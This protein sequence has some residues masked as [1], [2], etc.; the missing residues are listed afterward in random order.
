MFEEKKKLCS[1]DGAVK[2]HRTL[3]R[4]LLSSFREVNC[5]S[6]IA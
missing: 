5:Q 1:V 4:R 6:R 3:D 2:S